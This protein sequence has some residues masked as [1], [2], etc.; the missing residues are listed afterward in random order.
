M[1]RPL[2][3]SLCVWVLAGCGAEVQDAWDAHEDALHATQ[4]GK[5]IIDTAQFLGLVPSYTCGE[6]AKSE[7]SDAIPVMQANLG[8]CAQAAPGPS[9]DTTDSELLSFPAPGCDVFGATW[10]G[11][12]TATASGGD[13]RDAL[14]FDFTGMRIN[15]APVD[16]K[17]G[18][19]DC[20]D[21]TTWD[22]AVTTRVPA[23]SKTQELDLGY[24]G[25][26]VDRPGLAFI[27]TDYFILE[28]PAD[29][30]Y[31]GKTLHV[32]FKQLWW[33]AGL[34]LPHK[35]EL[36]YT[37]AHGHEVAIKFDPDASEMQ[38]SIDGGKFAPMPMP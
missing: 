36:D 27:G 33:E 11:Q 21:L 4:A 25:T 18:R 13:S 12:I 26:V 30:T 10:T 17:I 20:G 14:A 16:A 37:N 31:G 23:T 7:L 34:D 28:G 15:G 2:L 24:H 22:L 29:I 35:G 9:T 5:A 3:I 38:V 1:F 6:P 32:T 19:V 8:P